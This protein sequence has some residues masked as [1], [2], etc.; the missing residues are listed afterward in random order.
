M[1]T[2]V[3]GNFK[4]DK[5][6][7]GQFV[8][9]PSAPGYYN[10][11]KK[12]EWQEGITI[13]LSD[14]EQASGQGFVLRRGA[15]VTG[16]LFDA[17]GRPVIEQQVVLKKIGGSAKTLLI[18]CSENSDDRG[19]YRC[20]GLE[21]GKYI[22]GAGNDPKENAGMMIGTRSY[23]RA[24]YPGVA[25]EEQATPVEVTVEKEA[26]GI[27]LKLERKKKGF[28]VM[29]RVLDVDNGKPVPNIIIALGTVND[30]GLTMGYSIGGGSGSNAEG[31]FKLEG[32]IKGK[33][34]AIPQPYGNT[35][36]V[37][38]SVIL[39]VNEGDVTGI[40]VQM[41]KG[42]TI[43]GTAVLEEG[44]TPEAQRK[45]VGVNLVAQ[46]R[47]PKAKETDWYGATNFWSGIDAAGNV[48]FKGVRTGNV[49]INLTGKKAK[50]LSIRRLSKRSRSKAI[51]Q[52]P[53]S[54]I[55]IPPS[56]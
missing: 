25:Q 10:P 48:Q 47:D 32:I 41:R 15:V 54:A 52:I 11:Q 28:K 31:E 24:W 39:E 30:E 49:T 2:D 16:R 13:N 53:H 8:I 33:Y 43:Q 36:Y 14:G 42:A 51:R 22:V 3:D 56:Q 4:F 7:A 21:P 23:V 1:T 5:L 9:T 40:E 37:G 50:G 20:Y 55:P 12:N 46:A 38:E 27:D 26:S 29:G 17:N 44:A 45:L 18:M 34:R 19:V 35:E 6:L